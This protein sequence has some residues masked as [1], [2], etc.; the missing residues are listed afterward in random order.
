MTIRARSLFLPAIFLFIITS[1]VPVDNRM[2]SGFIPSNQVV[3]IHTQDFAAP[4][5]T[6]IADSMNMAAPSYLEFGSVNSP[7]F[8]NTTS[9][10]LVQFAPYSYQEEYGEDPVVDNMFVNIPMSGFTVFEED[11][12]YMPQNVYVYRLIKDLNHL[13]VYQDSFSEEYIDPIPVSKPGLI[14]L[15]RDTLRIDFKESFAYELL[16]ADSTERDSTEAFTARYKGL[17]FTTE[18]YNASNKGGR[19]NYMNIADAVIYLN[20]KS[21]GGDSLLSYYFNIYGTYYNIASHESSSLADKQP[22]ET[23]Y[24][25]GL[26]GVK[27]CL[28]VAALVTDIKAWGQ[29]QTPVID[30]DRILISRAELIIP[31]AI[32]TDGNYTLADNAPAT[33]YPCKLMSNDSLM[34]YSPITDIY[35]ENAGGSMNRSHWHYSYEITSYLQKVLKSDTLDVKDNLWIM[36]VY[37]VSSS[38]SGSSTYYVDNF[39]YHNTVLCGNL[40]DRPPYVRITYAVLQQ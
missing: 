9:S 19:I 35:N 17:Y 38:T 34:Y 12:R 28:D 7:L 27:P 29:A 6:T 8:G 40:S 24:Y 33:L 32:P 10:G 3:Y 23:L 31:V 14:Y 39:T 22:S 36:P 2:G 16:Q 15:G 4:M 26:A 20:Y 25:E 30:A 5:F 1:C 37:S 11:D 18:K 13:D 21:A